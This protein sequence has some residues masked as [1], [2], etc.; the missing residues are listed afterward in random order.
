MTT[1]IFEQ[2]TRQGLRFATVRGLITVEDL[3]V[4]PLNSTKNVCLEG[5]AVAIY[6]ELQAAPTV[7]FVNAGTAENTELTL[8]LDILK[9][10][11]E[12]K[13]AENAAKTTA[14]ADRQH[15]AHIDELILKAQ[16]RDMEGKSIE[17]LKA[18]RRG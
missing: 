17:E 13:Q 4:L 1:N 8:K 2:A 18:L 3:W 6:T 9:R 16:N 10:I 7:S 12:V 15:N 11:I 14:V 5:I